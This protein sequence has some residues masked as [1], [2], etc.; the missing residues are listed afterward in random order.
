MGKQIELKKQIV[1]DIVEQMKDA[2]SIVFVDY[3]GLSVAQDTELRRN[4]RKEGVTYKVYKN[5]LMV[6]ALNEMGIKDYDPTMFEGTTSVAIGTDEV[7]PAKVFAD[8]MKQYKKMDF[9]FGI[10]NGRIVSKEEIVALSK[11]PNKETLVAMLLGMLQAPVS[12]LARALSEIAKKEQ[13]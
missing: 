2:K 7:A 4:F 11:L 3:R 12:G 10:V 8:A 9:K 6:R 13:A 5:R 1:S